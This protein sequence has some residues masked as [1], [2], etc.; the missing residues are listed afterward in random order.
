[1][2]IIQLN[3]KYFNVVIGGIAGVGIRKGEIGEEKMH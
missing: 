1:L 3:M 2:V